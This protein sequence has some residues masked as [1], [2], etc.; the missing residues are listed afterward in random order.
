MKYIVDTYAWIEYFKGSKEGKKLKGLIDKGEEIITSESTLAEIKG[1]AIINDED[2][3]K[4]YSILRTN[5]EIDNVIEEDWIKAAFIKAEIRKKIKD[6]GL[7][8]SILLAKQLRYRCKIISG[9]P[10]FKGMK[11]IIFSGLKNNI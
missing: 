7:M 1:W 10:H 6:F 3:N 2:F 5:S 4:L 9:D 8:D 11:N